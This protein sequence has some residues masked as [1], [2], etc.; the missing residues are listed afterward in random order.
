MA[1]KVAVGS[2]YLQ[3]DVSCVRPNEWNPN[4]MPPEYLG[5][6]HNGIE[7]LLAKT[8]TIPPIVVRPAPNSPGKYEI[9]DGF[10]RW[11]VVKKLGRPVVDAFVLDVDDAQARILTDTL[12]YLRGEPDPQKRG[13]MFADILTADATLSI[14]DLA[15]LVPQDSEQIGEM[16]ASAGID[17][18]VFQEIL[19]RSAA[20]E[21][22]SEEERWVTMNFTVPA[23]VAQIVDT[24]LS[25]ISNVLTGKQR[26]LRALEYMAINSALTPL[27]SVTGA[28]AERA[29]AAAAAAEKE[30]SE[31]DVK[32]TSK[33][34]ELQ[35][36]AQAKTRKAGH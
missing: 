20:D 27:D 31:K 33:L 26:R 24:E 29:H 25:R 6:L 36:K 1:K 18:S 13:E 17:L 4:T 5:R 14:E 19:D 16:V 9:I 32:Q 3:L 22:P 30:E 34:R 11:K 35:A 21:E 8:G 15:K 2:Q 23:S 10:H 7:R 28:V 12:N